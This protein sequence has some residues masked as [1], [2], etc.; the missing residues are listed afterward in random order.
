MSRMAHMNSLNNVGIDSVVGTFGAAMLSLSIQLP[1][2]V[3]ISSINN[4]KRYDF[5]HMYVRLA[6]K[7]VNIFVKFFVH[8]SEKERSECKAKIRKKEKTNQF[9]LLFFLDC[10]ATINRANQFKCILNLFVRDT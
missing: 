10:M 7:Q 2:S 8:P 3:S 6:L 5:L 1:C 9:D 4:T